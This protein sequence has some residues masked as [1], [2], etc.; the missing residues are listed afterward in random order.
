MC[1]QPLF[2]APELPF[3]APAAGLL[4]AWGP[5]A[6]L[7]LQSVL[8]AVGLAHWLS[9][10]GLPARD[11][12]LAALLVTLGALAQ[13]EA[14]ALLGCWA[15]LPWVLLLAGEAS[16]WMAAPAVALLACAGSPVL[17][18][19]ALAVSGWG[20]WR[21]ATWRAAWLQGLLLAAP[22][23]LE[24]L[25][26]SIGQGSVQVP[27]WPLAW[28]GS[29]LLVAQLGVVALAAL[30]MATGLAR[31]RPLALL[32]P[33]AAGL[34]L[35]PALFTVSVAGPLGQGPPP[36]YLWQV[37]RHQ[38]GPG[39]LPVGLAALEAERWTGAAGGLAPLASLQRWRRLGVMGARDPDTLSLAAVGWLDGDPPQRWFQGV[40]AAMVDS[41]AGPPIPPSPGSTLFQRPL[42]LLHH[43]AQ[44]GMT[45]W[46]LQE[47]QAVAPGA[48]DQP[49]PGAA[50][51]WA[52]LSESYD[53]GWRALGP[54]GAQP[55]FETQAG[56]M[57]SRVD[58]AITL[59][60]RYRPWLALWG[61]GLALLGLGAWGFQRWRDFAL[62]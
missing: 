30:L 31:S 47:P 3:A 15:W 21:R 37:T 38:S 33:M 11:A 42:G 36:A 51:G 7:A 50:R 28:L 60:W 46:H 17:T 41:A 4:L 14:A 13:P 56:F 40:P 5:F 19:L 59:R 48:W 32:G 44:P 20:R 61:A 23:L 58:G 24:N 35:L 55:V 22:G 6:W 18:A 62:A 52:Y 43:R 45:A 8:L 10:G 1:G 34:A 53:P 12:T 27:G 57:A 39:G 16:A 26:L 25:R 29:P 2:G 49:L 54:R 9:R